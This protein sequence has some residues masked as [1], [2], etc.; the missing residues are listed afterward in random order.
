ML[1]TFTPRYPDVTSCVHSEHRHIHMYMYI[2]ICTATS[3]YSTCVHLHVYTHIYVHVCHVHACT[4]WLVLMAR[5]QVM[6]TTNDW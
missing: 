2:H 6:P 3:T 4:S 1:V 5:L